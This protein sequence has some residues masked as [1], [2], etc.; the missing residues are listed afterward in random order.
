MNLKTRIE[1]LELSAKPKEA[2]PLAMLFWQLGRKE[3]D[4][5][6]PPQDFIDEM[7]TVSIDDM[8]LELSKK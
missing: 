8:I 2:T 7:A 4:P 1:K 3:N 6:L 5:E